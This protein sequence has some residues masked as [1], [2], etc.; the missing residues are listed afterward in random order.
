MKEDI[1]WFWEALATNLGNPTDFKKIPINATNE[2]IKEF[3]NLEDNYLIA[4]T[5]GKYMLENYSHEEILDYVKYPTT[6]L[7]DSDLILNNAREWSNNR[8]NVRFK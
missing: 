3:G 2:E 4:Y 6:I 1:S 5:I 7:N 8:R